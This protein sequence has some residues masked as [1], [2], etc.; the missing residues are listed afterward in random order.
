MRADDTHLAAV[1]SSTLE[2][3]RDMGFY[4][5]QESRIAELTTADVLAALQ[6]RL[7]LANMVIVEAG[8][9]A[10]AEKEAAAAK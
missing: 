10:R 9:F 3:G 4:A 8:D 5:A 6:K 7:S 1:L 2:S